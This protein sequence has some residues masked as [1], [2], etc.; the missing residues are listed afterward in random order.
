MARLI[1]AGADVNA[2][3]RFRSTPLHWAAHDRAKAALL[4]SRAADVNAK[5][6]EGRTPL[7]LVASMG[8]NQQTVRLLIEHGADAALATANGQTPLM[9][10]AARG[11]VE[12]IDLLL[13]RK[14]DVNARTAPAKPH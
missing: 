4:L 2:R 14:V 9:A 8:A 6:I 13:D 3:N 7:F 5:Q 11:N 1:E 12:L 10:V